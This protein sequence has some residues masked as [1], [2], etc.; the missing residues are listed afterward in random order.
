MRVRRFW[1]VPVVM[2]LLAGGLALMLLWGV[3]AAE[4]PF[5]AEGGPLDIRLVGLRPVGSRT[6]YDPEG[7]PVDERP[8]Y[9]RRPPRD[10]SHEFEFFVQIPPRPQAMHPR[11]FVHAYVA[12]SVRHAGGSGF[13][14]HEIPAGEEPLTIP[15]RLPVRRRTKRTLF[16]LFRHEYFPKRTDLVVEYDYGEPEDVVCTFEGPFEK[17][18]ILQNEDPNITLIVGES[19]R[20]FEDTSQRFTLSCPGRA[21]DLDTH[22]AAYDDRGQRLDVSTEG[23]SSGASG[24][25][26]R[27]RVVAPILDR[28][29]RITVG[30]KPRRRVFRNI[31]LPYPDDPTV[32]PEPIRRLA[33]RMDIPVA[34]AWEIDA[35]EFK[36]WREALDV[37][38]LLRGSAVWRVVQFLEHPGEG[39]EKPPS[40]E[41]LPQASRERVDK[42]LATWKK[43]VYYSRA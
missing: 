32:P 14:L 9:V 27:F 16:G 13:G 36:T 19:R 25:T 5:A 28:L 4:S 15:L 29:A 3:D 6:V 17:G 18:Q 1:N 20:H 24:R 39:R 43:T 33:E 37:I 30:E 35:Q 11:T 41:A 40:Y 22:I 23:G 38:D 8:I 7:R 34:K 31:E 42:A 10:D 2:V 12:G 21:I 26:R